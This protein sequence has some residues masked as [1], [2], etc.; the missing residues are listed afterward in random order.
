MS[1]SQEVICN[2]LACFRTSLEVCCI[3]Q[4]MI[5]NGRHPKNHPDFRWINTVI[6]NLKT[7][8]S[9]TFHALRFENYADRY[10]GGFCYRFNRHINL[11]E[12]TGRILLATCKCTARP[13]R[14]PGSAEFSPKSS[15]PKPP[16]RCYLIGNHAQ[17]TARA[18]SLIC[19]FKSGEVSP[20][21]SSNAVN[22]LLSAV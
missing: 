11:A 4:P 16:S 21:R 3:H 6:S 7:S 10:L 9:G 19:S 14:L 17:S 1:V 2:G 8:F 20:Y 18:V 22:R 5:V 12:M 15:H 13:E